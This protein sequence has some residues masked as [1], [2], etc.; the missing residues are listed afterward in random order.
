METLEKGKVG[1]YMRRKGSATNR[2]RKRWEMLSV[3][4]IIVGD[5]KATMTK[6]AKMTRGTKPQR[7]SWTDSKLIEEREFFPLTPSMV[8]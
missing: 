1:S 3:C 2:C 5:G 8:I 4:F 7:P 6:H